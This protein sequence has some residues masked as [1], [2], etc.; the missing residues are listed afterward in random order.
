MPGMTSQKNGGT[1]TNYSQPSSRHSEL[2]PITKPPS[3]TCQGKAAL[4]RST[5]IRERTT[6]TPAYASSSSWT[7]ARQTKPVSPV[8]TSPYSSST[9]T[10]PGKIN[11]DRGV[12]TRSISAATSIDQPIT[13]SQPDNFSPPS[14]SP[15]VTPSLA[16]PIRPEP[17]PSS[18][19]PQ[20]PTSQIPSKAFLRLPAQ[21][22]LTPSISRLQGRGFVQ[23]MVKVSTQLESPPASVGDTP[24][25]NRSGSGR[26]T[27]VL[28]RWQPNL[29]PNPSSPP[30]SP[31]PRSVRRSATVNPMAEKSQPPKVAN[32]GKSLREATSFPSLRQGD[33][34]TPNFIPEKRQPENMPPVGLGSATTLMVFKP[35]PLAVQKP[36]VDELGF[37]HKVVPRGGLE[38]AAELPTPSR[39]PLSHVRSF[40]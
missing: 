23:N 29:S 24:E 3:E 34:R 9:T 14:K 37:Q 17:R 39:N 32:F 33:P 19:G 40:W 26:R 1:S 5:D 6:S 21:K 7:T 12:F 31:T 20:I 18:G 15:I 27:S 8:P 28:D 4:P 13:S 35:T 36:S 22:E 11:P 16:R 25:K 30:P 10:T 2:P 38:T